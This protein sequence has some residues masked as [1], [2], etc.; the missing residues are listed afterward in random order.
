M[1]NKIKQK[2]LEGIFN[3]KTQTITAAAILI[4]AASL[5]SRLL[6]MI[7]QRLLV[8]AFGAGDTLDAYFAAFQ[9]P[10]FAYNLLILATLSVAFIPVFCEYLNRDKTEA[11]R[12][13]NSILNLVFIA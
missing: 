9:V 13:A 3:N 5:G 11:W 2:I 12:I 6:G 4:G 1:L 10:D 7:R 8:G